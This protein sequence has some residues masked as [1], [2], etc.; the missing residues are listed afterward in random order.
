MTDSEMLIREKTE[1]VRLEDGRWQASFTGKQWN[2]AVSAPTLEQ[3]RWGLLEAFDERLFA[4]LC[5]DLGLSAKRRPLHRRPYRRFRG[6]ASP[7]ALRG[8]GTTAARAIEAKRSLAGN[9][10]T[11]S[12][13]V[14]V[15]AA[16]RLALTAHPGVAQ[17]CRHRPGV[18]LRPRQAG[19]VGLPNP[20]PP[21]A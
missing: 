13:S 2:L 6:A 3:A 14:A 10:L 16:A 9:P 7:A 4:I 17:R 8:N 20:C 21:A 19:S 1:Y 11:R 12:F 5:E 15:L 18:A